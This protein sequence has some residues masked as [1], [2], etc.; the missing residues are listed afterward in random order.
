MSSLQDT[1]ISAKQNSLDF[2]GEQTLVGLE[3][4]LFCFLKATSVDETLNMCLCFTKASEVTV[5]SP[6]KTC[7][8]CDLC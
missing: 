8:D 5:A 6:F 4:H 1:F 3:W 2:L 7:L